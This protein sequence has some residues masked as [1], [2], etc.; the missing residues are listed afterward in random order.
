MSIQWCH[1]RATCENIFAII[2]KISTIDCLASRAP[3]HPRAFFPVS[4]GLRTCW[5]SPKPLC[6]K[7]AFWLLVPGGRLSGITDSNIITIRKM[8]TVQN[9]ITT[10]KDPDRS[11]PGSFPSLGRRSVS[12]VPGKASARSPTGR[13]PGRPYR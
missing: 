5:D 10:Q 9:D 3:G 2:L 1:S 6:T 8:V 4:D 12:A 7:L 13:A 11:V